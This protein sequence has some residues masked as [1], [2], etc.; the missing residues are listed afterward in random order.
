VE[1][2]VSGEQAVMAKIEEYNQRRITKGKKKN[3]GTTRCRKENS[4]RGT[5]SKTWEPDGKAGTQLGELFAKGK[6]KE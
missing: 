2:G 3:H 4:R 5:I 1:A 6:K